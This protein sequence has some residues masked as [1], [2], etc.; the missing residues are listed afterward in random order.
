MFKS[1]TLLRFDLN[2][3]EYVFEFEDTEFG[4]VKIPL[5]LS[6]SSDPDWEDD[7]ASTTI[8]NEYFKRNLDVGKNLALYVIWYCRKYEDSV[9]EYCK[10]QDSNCSTRI[11]SWQSYASGRDE[12]VKKLTLIQ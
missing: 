12:W 6:F 5:K 11:E 10:W 2:T 7:M 8:V 1:S 4:I 9:E 3:N